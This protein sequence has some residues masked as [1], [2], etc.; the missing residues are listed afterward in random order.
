M[1]DGVTMLSYLPSVILLLALRREILAILLS[2]KYEP[3]IIHFYLN[4]FNE[5]SLHLRHYTIVMI[6]NTF[7]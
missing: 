2:I 6:F 7:P 3:N 1:D 4:L 5:I